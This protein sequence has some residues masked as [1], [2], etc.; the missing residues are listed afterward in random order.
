MFGTEVF[1]NTARGGAALIAGAIALGFAPVAAAAPAIPA[2]AAPCNVFQHNHAGV[3]G[4]VDPDYPECNRL[5]APV[6]KQHSVTIA[7]S[8]VAPLTTDGLS[9]AG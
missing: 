5:P 8:D 9:N 1:K 6:R 7:P 2:P 3:P 4:V